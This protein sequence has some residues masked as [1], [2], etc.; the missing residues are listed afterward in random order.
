MERV[1]VD[2]LEL[3]AEAHAPST[4]VQEKQEETCGDSWVLGNNLAA[5]NVDT[6]L[7][8]RRT[9]RRILS[10]AF[11]LFPWPCTL[12][13]QSLACLPERSRLLWN[14]RSGH[15]IGKYTLFIVR[16]EARATENTYRWVLV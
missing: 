15:L 11:V 8:K 10:V 4:G 7:T 6:V 2:F 14:G 13:Q 12:S 9:R 5:D 16:G 3:L 1:V